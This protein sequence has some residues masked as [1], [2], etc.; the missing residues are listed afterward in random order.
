MDVAV[1]RLPERDDARIEAMDE[2][3]QRQEVDGAFGAEVQA[4][5]HGRKSE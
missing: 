4:V 3:A 1:V 2:R 5:F